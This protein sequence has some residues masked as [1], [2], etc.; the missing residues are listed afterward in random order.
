VPF[1]TR[2]MPGFDGVAAGQTATLRCPISRTYHQLL[3]NY[4]GATLAQLNALRV[5]ANGE[6]ITRIT[7]M[8]RLDVINQYEGRATTSGGVIVLD[9]ERY[10]LLTRAGREVTALGTGIV[11]RAASP[12][13]PNA[14][15]DPFPISTLAIEIDID[16]AAVGPTLSARAIQSQARPVG[17]VKKIREYNYAASAAGVFEISDL[18]KRGIINKILFSGH[19]ANVYNS[20]VVERDNFIVFERTTA[21]NELIQ[22]DGVRVPQADYW[23]YDPTEQGYA[24]EGLTTEGVADL[25]FKLDITN[26]GAFTMI[27]E[28]LEPLEI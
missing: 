28:S 7:E 25:R 4:G 14:L 13:D 6:V 23:V 1:T 15:F 2:K 18:P 17:L 22:S 19:T 9:F 24:A 21:E 8:A 11:R 16:A 12:T 10:G 20:L 26:P 27:V 5:V 3:I